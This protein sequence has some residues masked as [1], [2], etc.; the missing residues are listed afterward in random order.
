[1]EQQSGHEEKYTFMRSWEFLQ[2]KYSRVG[3]KSFAYQAWAKEF[4]DPTE[5]FV[6]V[7]LLV[8]STAL[9]AGIGLAYERS[10]SNG[11]KH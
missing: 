7:Y 8:V 1:M 9:W 5:Y 11:T 2:E 6:I 3:V 10:D 4:A